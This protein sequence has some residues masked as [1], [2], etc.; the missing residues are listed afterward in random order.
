MQWNS[1]FP[2]QNGEYHLI[3]MFAGRANVSRMWSWPYMHIFLNKFQHASCFVLFWD[4]HVVVRK[5]C[6]FNVARFDLDYGVNAGRP[7]QCIC[8][9]LMCVFCCCRPNAQDFN[10][11]A[12]FLLE[13]QTNFC[14]SICAICSEFTCLWGDCRTAIFAGLM[15]QPGGLSMWGPDCRSWSMASRGTTMRSFLNNGIGLDWDFVAAGNQMVSRRLLCWFWVSAYGC[16]VSILSGL[17]C[18]FFAF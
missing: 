4:S 13:A 11:P 12:G 2:W 10:K 14:K 15:M 6:G 5:E 8:S 3:D 16:M 17:S 18:A 1:S 7:G 9:F